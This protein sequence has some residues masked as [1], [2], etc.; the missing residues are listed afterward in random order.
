MTQRTRRLA[1]A[2]LLV[3]GPT[4]LRVTPA[5]A[6]KANATSKAKTQSKAK[7]TITVGDN[8]YKASK[9][10]VLVGDKVTWKFIGRG[11][12]DVVVD[13]GPA[14]FESKK[15]SYG[16]KFSQVLK[17]PGVYQIVCTLHPS[18]TMKITVK[19]RPAPTTTTLTP[20]ST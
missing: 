4:L 17:V 15:R 2:A 18:M 8:F 5:T 9:V 16:Y 10:T 14:K 20:P 12:H 13:K 19:A 7:K 1:A 6:A 11:I 3:L